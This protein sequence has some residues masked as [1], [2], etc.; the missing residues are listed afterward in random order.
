MVSHL[1]FYQL[2]LLGL[3]WLCCM[4]HAAWSSGHAAGVQR[5][6]ERMPPSPTRTGSHRPFLASPTSPTAR[7]V[8]RPPR[9]AIRPPAPHHP[10]WSPRE[11][12]RARWTRRRTSAPIRTVPIGAGWGWAISVPTVIPTVA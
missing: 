5:P 8:R 4:L 3:L 7:P 10:A 1:F 6:P 9:L 2:V 11:D 12:G